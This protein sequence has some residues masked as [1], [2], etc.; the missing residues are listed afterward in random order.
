MLL[1]FWHRGECVRSSHL[2]PHLL[3]LRLIIFVFIRQAPSPPPQVLTYSPTVTHAP[4]TSAAPSTCMGSTPGW[5][6][7]DGDGCDWYERNDDPGCPNYGSSFGGEMGVA[8]DNCCYC[9]G[10]GVSVFDLVI[11]GLIYYLF[12]SSYLSSFVRLL[13]RLLRC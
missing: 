1:L 11:S 5:E 3:S 2:W 10:T 7:K 13:P 4:T 6:D 8:D 9:F 12:V